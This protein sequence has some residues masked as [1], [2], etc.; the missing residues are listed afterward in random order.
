MRILVLCYEYPPLGGGGGRVAKSIAEQMVSRGYEVRVQTAALG[1]HSQHETISGVEVFR[2]AS[3]RRVPD[4]CGVHE[5]GLY[6]ATSFFPTLR[7]LRTWKPD[8]IHAHFA[9]PTGALAWAVHR[10][11]GIPY[12]LTAHLGDVPGGVPEQT[13]TLFR[14]VDPVARRIWRDAAAATAVS[15]FVQEIAERAYQRPV[16]RILNGIDLRDAPA[17]PPAPHH[18]RHLVFIGRLNPQK[19]PVFLFDALARLLHLPWTLTFIGD[20]PLLR[21]VQARI[22]HHGLA[23]RVT[24]TGWLDSGAVHRVLAEGD[25]LCLPSLSE[26]L[27]VVGIEALKHGLAIVASDIPGIRDVLD[28]GL[29]GY[30]VPLGDLDAFAQK[31]AHLLESDTTLFAMKQA[32][33]EKARAF[34]LS[35]IADQYERV[36]STAR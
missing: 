30:R 10:L 6:V 27:P 36:L 23:E 2:T 3:G 29:N 24:C 13:D 15:S 28:D 19:N 1:W 16:E 4:T 33:W 32:S 11:T 7:H 34:D 25:I 8:V 14:L 26:G 18:P 31:L 35:R 5:M 12:V 20:G 9:V 17:A 21:E 22:A